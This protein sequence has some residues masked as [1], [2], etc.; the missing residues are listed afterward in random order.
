MSIV[1]RFTRLVRADVHAV[2]DRLEEPEAL[3]RQALRE[4]EAALAAQ[5]QQLRTWQLEHEQLQ[6]RNAQIERTLDTLREEIDLCF[7]AGKDELL[8]SSLRRRLENERLR[9]MLALRLAELQQQIG[10]AAPVIAQQ[11][12]RLQSIRQKAELLDLSA[13][14]SV[15]QAGRFAAD[16][17]CIG[18]AEI[19]LALLRERQA[20]GLS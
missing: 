4:M 14:P 5:E 10:S 13:P 12:E 11:R 20:R 15:L 9:K 2:L 17:I 7:A 1:S 8:R 16:D 3:L 6:Q 18:E 19:E